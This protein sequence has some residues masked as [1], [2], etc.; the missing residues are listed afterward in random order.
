MNG[1]IAIVGM[2]CIYPDARSPIELWQNVLAQRRAFRC[3]PAERLRVSDYYNPDREA[4]DCTY[5]MQAAVIEG[6]EFD[7]VRFGIAGTAFRATDLVHWL[8][9]DVASQAL[10]DAGFHNGEGLPAEN[11]GVLI[12]NTLTGD[13]SRANLMRLR[14]PYVRRTVEAALSYE[15]RSKGERQ[16]FMDDLE[17]RYKAPF[18][19]TN[20]ETLAGALSNTIAGGICN[21][22]DLKGG[23][24]TIDGACASSLLAVSKA[25]SSLSEGELDVALSGGVD[26]SLDAFELVG[27]AKAGVLASK[28]MRIYDVRSDGFWPGEGCGVVVLMRYEDAIA[29]SRRIYALIRGW[30]VS[31]DGAG[32]MTRPEKSGQL[33]ALR[34][35]YGRAGFGIET[36][37]YFEGH[38]TGTNVGDTTELRAL[39]AARRER[40]RDTAHAVIGSVKAN[41]GH[42]KAAAGV[43]GLIKTALALHHQ[44]IPPTTGCEQP[45]GELA[46]A[47]ASLSVTQEALPWPL[48][49]PLRAGVSAMGFG[50]IN[51]HLALEGVATERRGK[52]SASEQSSSD[53]AQDAELFLMAGP[54]A[55]EVLKWMEPLINLAPKLSRAELTDVAAQLAKTLNKAQIRA[56]VVASTPAELARGLAALQTWLQNG[57]KAKIDLGAG[58]FLGTGNDVPRIG[59]LFPGQGSPIY[60]GGG[61]LSRRF[62]L[63]REL[64]AHANVAFNKDDLST[65]TVQP[66]VVMASLAALRVLN[67]LGCTASVGIGHS[68]GELTAIHW[69]GALDDQALLRIAIARGRAMTQLESCTGAMMAIDAPLDEITDL[70]EGQDVSIACFN[71]PRQTVV[72]GQ[73]RR[74]AALRALA[75][76]KG[77]RTFR[78]E[79]SQAFHS[80]LMAGAEQP[81]VEALSGEAFRPLVRKVISTV[82]GAILPPD[83]DLRALL[84]RQLGSPVRFTDALTA[85]S[86]DVDLLIEVGPGEIL[87]G[88]VRE[89]IETPVVALDAGG[90][91]IKG[92]LHAVGATFAL[93][94]QVDHHALFAERFTR[95]F[96]L[97]WRPR[98][99]GN[100]CELVSALDDP[101][102][103]IA[104]R[105]VPTERKEFLDAKPADDTCSEAKSSHAKAPARSAAEILRR[106]LT[107]RTELPPSAILNE[108]RMATDLRLPSIKVGQAV[109]ETAR[110]LGVLPPV[111][112]TDYA[113]ATFAEIAQAIEDLKET[114]ESGSRQADEEFPAGVDSWIRPF[115]IE[116]VE[117]PL[118]RHQQTATVGDWVVFAPCD[119]P[120][121]S[122]LSQQLKQCGKGGG[123]VVCLPAEANYPA[124]KLLLEGAR[125]VL[126]TLPNSCQFVLVQHR[127]GAAGFA[128]T[129]HLEMPKVTTSVIDVPFDNPQSVE[130]VMAEILAAEGYTEAHYDSF[131]TRRESRLC[132]I[133]LNDFRGEMPLE[134]TDVLLV[135]GGGKGIAAECALDLGRKTGVRLALLGRSL[136]AEDHE[137]GENLDRIR[138]AGIQCEYFVADVTKTE[139]VRTAVRTA[140]QKLGPITAVLHSAG[141]N[142]PQALT[143]LDE[144]AFRQTLAPKLEGIRN[145]LAAID[146]DHL[147]LLVTFSSIIARTGLPGEADYAVANEWLSALTEQFQ[148]EH[149]RCR[150]LALEWSIW[151]GVGMGQRLGRVDTLMHQGITPISPEE[152]VRMLSSL[153]SLRLPLVSVIATGRF[154][155]TPTLKFEQPD[156]PSWRFLEKP[157]VH[158]PGVELVVDSELSVT[159]DPYLD[160]HVFQGDRLFPAVLGLEAIAQAAMALAG[161]SAPPTF[162][163]VQFSRPIVVPEA[164][165]LIIRAG[166]LSRRHDRIEVTLRTSE[167]AFLVDCFHAIC[168]FDAMADCMET[169]KHILDIDF[170]AEASSMESERIPVNPKNDLYGEILF[171]RGRFQRLSGY[172]RLWTKECV[173]EISPDDS[174]VWFGNDLPTTLVLGDPAARDAALHSIQACIPHARIFPVGLDRGEVSNLSKSNSLMVWAEE[175]SHDRDNFVYNMVIT[176]L[177]GNELERWFGLRLRIVETLPEFTI[178]PVA[179][180]GPYLERRLEELISVPGMTVAVECDGR[181]E[182]RKSSDALIR[183]VLRTANPVLRRPDG[184]P[185]VVDGRSV[186]VAHA[187]GL[188]VTVAAGGLVGCDIE[189]VNARSQSSWNDLLGTAGATLAQLILSES[190]NDIGNFDIAATRVWVA[191]ECL[192][193]AGV[194][195]ES[196]LM[197]SFVEARWVCLTAGSLTIATFVAD[198]RSDQGL[199]VFGILRDREQ[200]QLYCERM[201]RR[202]MPYEDEWIVTVGDTNEFGSVYFAKYFERQGYCR[203]KFLETEAHGAIDELRDA[204]LALV[205]ANCSCEY[206]SEIFRSDKVHIRM[207]LE[208]L[209]ATS[210]ALSFDYVRGSNVVARGAQVVA[211]TAH[212]PEHRNVSFPKSLLLALQR[213]SVGQQRHETI[214]S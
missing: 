212:T 61:I 157:R 125:R 80:P 126:V 3:L 73:S 65:A 211:V 15:N 40:M 57:V 167:T 175:I 48:D 109:A 156:L 87:S 38:G 10:A 89:N 163:D 204:G 98:F 42:T 103:G 4:P 210:L 29:Q 193:K 159:K 172:R 201:G 26:L 33:L 45:H 166:A 69:A 68:L 106:I 67:I 140:E 78:L 28:E 138:A 93:G 147:R 154:G 152:G 129:L 64:Y 127:L 14:W 191:K 143:S 71:S 182:L 113:N 74:V 150:C 77:L 112:L 70:L 51:T 187:A 192:K 66:V 91:S 20:E 52:L 173:A 122:S 82:T 58:V 118:L 92:L 141:T 153:L 5:S 19:A 203:D 214:A 90:P 171:H 117:R 23:G 27:F 135:T 148:E 190:C 164:G 178:W 37:T 145:I 72:S 107:R 184:K 13:M 197:L 81:F 36:V 183:R 55:E 8:A 25:C 56:G 209:K 146:R 177:I 134:H 7:R 151:S 111:A 168:R 88:L 50:G 17:V 11:T 83:E 174:T 121:K 97:H 195:T 158:Y 149:P 136:P 54:S 119:H 62:P 128:R 22:F 18:P 160:D 206:Y 53:S 155:P 161:S 137:L 196:P 205:T 131:G 133:P 199:V 59:F 105:R 179:L 12:G 96:D 176:D 31:S 34:R 63:A 169:R 110:E 108:S 41:I 186:S 208:A 144:I 116:L 207:Y 200:A 165:S 100:P 102:K 60:R 130:W 2:A 76:T 213:Y 6:Y 115:K 32:A 21:H 79:V 86:Q 202:G 139:A 101:L 24:F 194:R 185:E 181:V 16:T 30:G 132:L 1:C 99:L 142:T 49:L 95:S 120:L 94:V 43:A 123:V 104:E 124:V 44:V 47:S 39:C 188:L 85:V 9:L 189:P 35:A 180:L 114:G 75:K 84:V 46:D 162:E 198:L 170:R